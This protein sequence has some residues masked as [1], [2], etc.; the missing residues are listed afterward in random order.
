MYEIQPMA[1]S[2]LQHLGQIYSS[3]GLRNVHVADVY[4][5]LHEAARVNLAV[6]RLPEDDDDLYHQGIHTH[7]TPAQ[8]VLAQELRQWM[9]CEFTGASE[10]DLSAALHQAAAWVAAMFAE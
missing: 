2:V 7:P 8:R 4:T 9:R 10:Q 3:R 6:V 5:V 1:E